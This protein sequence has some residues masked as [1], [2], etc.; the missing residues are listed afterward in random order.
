MPRPLSS[1]TMSMATVVVI[2]ATATIAL[3]SYYTVTVTAATSTSTSTSDSTYLYMAPGKRNQYNQDKIDTA[4]DPEKYGRS[5]VSIARQLVGPFERAT[6]ELPLWHKNTVL[7]ESCGTS[8]TPLHVEYVITTEPIHISLQLS[9]MDSESESESEKKQTLSL[10]RP[11]ILTTTILDTKHATHP[12]VM[13]LTWRPVDGEAERYTQTVSFGAHTKED[14]L[15]ALTT[16]DKRFHDSA[17]TQHQ[18]HAYENNCA[19]LVRL[20]S[21]LGVSADEFEQKARKYTMDA[22]TTSQHVRAMV[23]DAS[24]HAQ[25]SGRKNALFTSVGVPEVAEHTWFAQN[26]DSLA[27]GSMDSMLQQL[28]ERSMLQAFP[29][30]QVHTER[31]L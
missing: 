20:L 12:N 17:H 30:Y 8:S 24:G 3:S 13:M 25:G 29:D 27:S 31:D 16:L 5:T 11:I 1:M 18:F 2:V 19:V 21:H 22:V 23:T 4:T 15:T 6:S 26:K 7:H 14:I 28:Y 9:A 10:C